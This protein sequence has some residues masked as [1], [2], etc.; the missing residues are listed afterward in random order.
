M[1][2]HIPKYNAVIASSNY[3]DNTFYL[4]RDNGD[5]VAIVIEAD[6]IKSSSHILNLVEVEYVKN[7]IIL[8]KDRDGRFLQIESVINN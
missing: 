8:N 7:Y 4:Y 6:R 2:V 5:E 3:P 1:I